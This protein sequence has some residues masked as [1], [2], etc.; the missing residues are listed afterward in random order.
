MVAVG[1]V[2]VVED[3][4]MVAVEAAAMVEVGVVAAVDGAVMVAVGVEV[5]VEAAE[6]IVVLLMVAVVEMIGVVTSRGNETPP[7]GAG[8]LVGEVLHLGAPF[9][10]LMFKAKQVYVFEV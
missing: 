8:G 4:V 3:V 5:A 10:D 2:V 9:G 6:L 1:V 7:I